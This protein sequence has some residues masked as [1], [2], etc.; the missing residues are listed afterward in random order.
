MTAIASTPSRAALPARERLLGLLAAGLSGIVLLAVL[1]RVA[2]GRPLL[3]AGNDPW[4]VL[5][6]LSVLPALPLGAW[7]LLQ[8]KG[9]T[10]H[11]RL[12]RVWAGLMMAAALSSFA[13]HGF[14]GRL[15]PFH[16][17][18]VLTLVGVPRAVLLAARGDIARH[19]RTILAVATGL[20]AAGL[21][22]FAP[23]RLLGA[24]L[25]G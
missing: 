20:V 7:L 14:T 22:A 1:H 8:R 18:S 19:R 2:G 12:G 24:W 13:L 11:R 25:F 10:L 16:I 9:G 23:G 5:H 21:F 3:P 4:L 17:L 15:G 6:L